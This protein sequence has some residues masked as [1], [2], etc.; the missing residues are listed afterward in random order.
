MQNK[1]QDHCNVT[2]VMYYQTLEKRTVRLLSAFLGLHFA[3]LAGGLPNGHADSGTWV[4]NPVDNNWNTPANWSSNTVPGPF[5]TATFEVSNTTNISILLPSGDIKEMV[6]NPAAS[7]YSFTALPGASLGFFDGGITNLS[8]VEQNFVTQTDEAGKS[9]VFSMGGFSGPSAGDQVTFTQEGAKLSGA[10]G[11]QVGFSGN[12]TN[13]GTA[14]FHNLGATVSEGGGGL[15]SFSGHSNAAESTIINEGGQVSGAQGGLTIFQ[16]N[17]PSAANATIIANGGAV[18]G[19]G[20]G[21]ISFYNS[22]LAGNSTLIANGGV[23]DGAGGSIVFFQTTD[24]GTARV[25]LFGNGS[26]DLSEHSSSPPMTLGSL[27]GDG[28]VVLSQHPLTIGG[29]SLSTK[30]SGTI[31]GNGSLVKAGPGTLDLSGANLYVR[32]TT[33]TQGVLTVNNRSGSGTGTGS[34]NVDAGTLG[35]SGI[36]AG[37]VTVGTGSGGG[38]FLT[39]GIGTNKQVTLTIQ[40]ALTF[41]SDSTYS[42]TFQGNRNRVRTDLV[43]ANGV[44]I[45]GGTISISS[46]SQNRI[47]RG[48]VL[49]VISN[50]SASPIN[51]A[52]SNLPDGAIVN[53]NGNNLQASYSGGD[54]NDLTLTVVP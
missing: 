23:N 30:F 40:S 42:Y 21:L 48:T 37:A 19:A 9:G 27:E 41:N 14:T 47:R 31:Q 25:E 6:F 38:A 29:N 5:D 2:E 44:T 15:V 18:S 17:N 33:V 8:G 22:S 4:L 34:V 13:A 52:F 53:V 12:A 7:A 11:G 49:T 39:P 45:N 50:T 32:G 26:L 28:V 54:G 46:G 16:V 51:G 3:I 43:I 36:I 24:G 1:R 10:I 35:G 20:G